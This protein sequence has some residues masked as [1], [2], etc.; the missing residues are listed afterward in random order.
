MTERSIP[1]PYGVQASRPEDQREHVPGSLRDRYNPVPRSRVL[2]PFN[3]VEN[4]HSRI[5]MSSILCAA[6]ITVIVAAAGV[7]FLAMGQD[8][9]WWVWATFP[10]AGAMF[11]LL[12][13]IWSGGRDEES[14]RKTRWNAI[15][16]LFGAISIPRTWLYIHPSITNSDV[17]R[18]PLILAGI[19]F[20]LF[21]LFSGM[22]GGFMRWRERRA[23]LLGYRQADKWARQAGLGEENDTKKD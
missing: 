11:G 2:K 20:G 9:A 17:M 8:M 12:V 13:L 23:E 6:A 4:S 14:R 5:H 18:D 15:F 21:L 10:L 7:P 19:G 1:I 3:S 22:A 16:G